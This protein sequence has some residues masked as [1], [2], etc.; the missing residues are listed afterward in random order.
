[1]KQI[2]QEKF[3][4]R[5]NKFLFGSAAAIITNLG[6][7]AGLFSSH[8]ARGN[9]IGSILVIAVADN[10]S[11]T[12]GIHIYQEAEGLKAKEV[13]LSSFT[14]FISRFVVSM[15]FVIIIIAFPL[16]LAVVSC[17]I[18]GLCIIS[19]ISYFIAVYKGS[20]PYIAVLEHL[21]VAAIV[22]ISSRTLGN[23]IINQFYR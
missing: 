19:L 9:I 6:I 3:Q 2:N 23:F 10:I 12:L 16:K 7:I 18:L 20:N 1:M 21:A 22:I 5:K 11:D 4:S 13:W 14:N 8:N 15:I 17:L